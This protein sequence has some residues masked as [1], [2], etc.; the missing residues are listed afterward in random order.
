MRKRLGRIGHEAHLG[1]AV[2]GLLLTLLLRPEAL[3]I[4]LSHFR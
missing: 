3:G 2:G 4:F 1:G